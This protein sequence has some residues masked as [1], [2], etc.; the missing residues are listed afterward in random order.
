MSSLEPYLA[1]NLLI[2]DQLRR[3]PTF[4]ALPSDPGA[5]LDLLREGALFD[6]PAGIEV[7]AAGDAPALIVVTQ[8][9]LLERETGRSWR[10][11]SHLG[12]AEA[13][14]GRCFDGAIGTAAPTLLYWLDGALLGGFVRQC[15]ET[16]ARLLADSV[17]AIL[18]QCPGDAA[19]GGRRP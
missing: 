15:P 12:L 1:P 2:T 14:S 13:L 16:A 7:V 19:L 17:F 11:G 10:A 18:P 3:A 8:G 5:C 9:A 4:A 6:I